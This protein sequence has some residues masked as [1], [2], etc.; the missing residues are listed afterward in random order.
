[1]EPH[2]SKHQS[3]ARIVGR[4]VALAISAEATPVDVAGQL[5]I[6]PSRNG[7]ALAVADMCRRKGP[8]R[9]IS[10]VEAPLAQPP[11]RQYQRFE[12]RAVLGWQAGENIFA[13]RQ[14]ADRRRRRGA[15]G[16]RRRGGRLRGGVVFACHHAHDDLVRGSMMR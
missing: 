16:H 8:E 10:L 7:P 4:P 13:A 15:R 5:A 9:K 1:V 6:H 2:R 11:G 3:A 12:N 14:V